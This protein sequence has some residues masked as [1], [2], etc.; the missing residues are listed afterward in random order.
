MPD[1]VELQVACPC[2]GALLPSAHSESRRRVGLL[3]SSWAVALK[4]GQAIVIEGAARLAFSTQI[5]GCPKDDKIRAFP[6]FCAVDAQ[7]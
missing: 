7:P 1:E 2:R 6:R 5:L 3:A 4:G